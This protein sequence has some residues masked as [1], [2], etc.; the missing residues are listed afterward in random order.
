VV[1]FRSLNEENIQNIVSLELDKVSHRLVEHGLT[2]TAT[3]VALTQLGDLGYDP[4]MGARPLKRIIQQ[5][6]EDPLSDAVLAGEF[7]DGDTVLV[8]V[9]DGGTIILT[10]ELASDKETEPAPAA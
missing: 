10:K 2:L 7:V 1:V 4:E 8:D 6:V 3:P 5:H 9:D